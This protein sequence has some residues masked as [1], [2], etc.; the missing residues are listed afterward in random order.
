MNPN[1]RGVPELENQP[2]LVEP[3]VDPI[4]MVAFV[5][6]PAEVRTTYIYDNTS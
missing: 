2:V 5:I 6:V 1:N 3:T 4:P